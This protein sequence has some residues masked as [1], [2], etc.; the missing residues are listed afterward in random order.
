MTDFL[1]GA[2]LSTL[3]E[4]ERYGGRFF[5]LDGREDDAM[6]ILA[7]RGVNHV[8]LRLWNDPYSETGENYGGG[9]C[10]LNTAAALA[11]RAK[12]LGLSWQLVFHYS[13]FWT[14]PGK[15]NLPKSW[16]GLSP[17]A[18]EKAVYAFTRDALQSLK[19]Q[20]LAPELVSVG[21]EITNGL[22]WPY[23]KVPA[24]ERITELV[25]AGIRAVR[26]TL[27]DSKV[28][29]HLD[30][31][32]RPEVS[33]EW[34]SRCAQSGGEDFDW[35]GLSYYPYWSGSM[36]GLE[37]NLRCL[38]ERYHKP[39]LITETATGH[40]LRDY[41]AFEGL[42]LGERKGPAAGEGEAASVPYPM[43]PEGQAAFLTALAALIRR[44]PEGLGAGLVYWEPA[45]LPV[46]GSGW[47]SAAGLCYLRDP[48]PGGN[49]WANQALF[50]YEGR[51]LPALEC[52]QKL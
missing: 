23:G 6:S 14:D 40:T 9:G 1:K 46:K 15:Q 36:A 45:W 20:G 28:L 43:T 38:A 2:D 22:L 26:D 47:A 37:K 32:G 3:S 7:R 19:A 4:V 5:D 49:E 42:A 44:T 24:W 13:D 48:G 12:D 11:K 29:I 52:F 30:N 35:I 8:R 16:R 34:F 27:P 25:S 51:A 31:G 17:A 50:D 39:V 10:D 21:N 33:R 41:A 18:L